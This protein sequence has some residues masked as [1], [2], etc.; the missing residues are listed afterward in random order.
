MNE[1]V[2]N[3]AITDEEMNEFA[4]SAAPAAAAPA[5]AGVIKIG[6]SGPLTNDYAVY[7]K[8]VDNK[9]G[10]HSFTCETEG[11]G[12]VLTGNHNDKNNDCKCDNC[13]AELEHNLADW[14]KDTNGHWNTCLTCRKNLNVGAHNFGEAKPVEGHTYHVK[15]CVDCGFE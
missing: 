5:A 7:G 6:T 4:L 14:G 8:A 11:C 12:Y 9:D 13:A 3:S 2:K 1:N 15:S 10:T